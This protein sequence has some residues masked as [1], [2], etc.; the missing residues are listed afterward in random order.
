MFERWRQENFFKYLRAEYAL[1]ALADYQT[2]AADPERTVPNPLRRTMDRA[3]REAK[4]D[5]QELSSRYGLDA[6]GSVE[7]KRRTMR[8]FKIAASQTGRAIAAAERRVAR[9]KRRR[10]RLP[11]RV[12]VAQ[13]VDGEVV[14][15]STERKHLTNC[16]KMVAYQA[17][18]ELTG[19]IARHYR[20]AEDEGRTLAQTALASTAD[21]LVTDTELEVVLAP[22]SSAHRT[23]AVAALC[24]ELTAQAAVFPGS[25]LRLRYRVKEPV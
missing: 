16:L 24:D 4:L 2:E 6:L 12:P 14:R 13:V 5:L 19:L 8:G 11:L 23:K 7:A 25:K 1:D 18:S 15:L 21:L 22:L 10:A 20:R 3:L 17:E 9:I